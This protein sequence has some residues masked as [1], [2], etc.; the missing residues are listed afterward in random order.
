[1]K[2]E[3][4]KMSFTEVAGSQLDTFHHQIL[5]YWFQESFLNLQMSKICYVQIQTIL[6]QEPSKYHKLHYQYIIME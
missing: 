4:N 2:V 5:A 3:S 1:M 6:H